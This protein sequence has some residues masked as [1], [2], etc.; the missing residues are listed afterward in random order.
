MEE[1]E[2]EKIYGCS[3]CGHEGSEDDVCPVCGGQMLPKG[4]SGE[5]ILGG[6][7]RGEEEE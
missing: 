3:E 6:E 2:S 4:E 7:E 1:N 5:G